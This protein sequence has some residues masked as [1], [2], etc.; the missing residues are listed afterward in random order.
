MKSGKKSR[1][2]F[3]L[4]LREFVVILSDTE[5][6]IDFTISIDVNDYHPD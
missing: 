2:T 1:R 5:V 3:A 4:V 6:L